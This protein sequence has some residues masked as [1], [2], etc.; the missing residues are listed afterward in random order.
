MQ[1]SPNHGARPRQ[2][3]GKCASAGLR[4][5]RTQPRGRGPAT[6]T[7]IPLQCRG[8]PGASTYGPWGAFQTE[9]K[10]GRARRSGAAPPAQEAG[11]GAGRGRGLFAAPG[12]IMPGEMVTLQIGQCGNQV[13][14]RFWELALRELADHNK[15]GR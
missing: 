10:K 13:G 9:R 12:S 11:A 7:R 1:P 3:A 15:K 2:R 6:G 5:S 14:L 4:P 8:P